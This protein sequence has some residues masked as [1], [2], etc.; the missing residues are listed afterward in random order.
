MSSGYIKKVTVDCFH[1]VFYSFKW[2]VWL[3]LHSTCFPHPICML[4]FYSYINVDYHL[5]KKNDNA[6]LWRFIWPD[7]TTQHC[8][9]APLALPPGKSSI[10]ILH[11]GVFS[12]HSVLVF[13]TLFI[14]ENCY[15]T[16]LKGQLILIGNLMS[17]LVNNHFHMRPLTMQFNYNWSMQQF[18]LFA[19][20]YDYHSRQLFRL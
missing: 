12:P 13:S 19:D 18:W 10:L 6:A 16:G 7:D 20:D 2:L 4:P 5:C 11:A 14:A 17:W 9:E 8:R 3:F 15:S 1:P